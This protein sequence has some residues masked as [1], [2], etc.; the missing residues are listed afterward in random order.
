MRTRRTDRARPMTAN[1]APRTLGDWLISHRFFPWRWSPLLLALISGLLVWAALPPLSWWPLGWIAPL[2]WLLLIRQRELPGRHPYR[3]IYLASVLCWA[4]TMQGIRLA[5][6]ANYIGLVALALYLGIYLPLF[7]A[8]A[9]FAHHRWK[10]TL[11][12]AAPVVWVGVEV[13]RGY[14]PLGFSMALLGHT[15]IEQLTLV[16]IAD[17]FGPYTIS[18]VLMLVASCAL[19]VTYGSGRGNRNVWP[20]VVPVVILLLVLVY[21]RFRLEQAAGSVQEPLRVALI[22]GSIDTV[23]NDDPTRPHET[24]VQYVE[25]TERACTQF[26]PL[27]LVIWPETMFPIREILIDKGVSP[28]ADELLDPRRIEDTQRVFDQM[29]R[30][31]AWRIN[32]RPG[33]SP[34]AAEGTSNTGWVF[35]VS[36]WQLGNHPAR[37][38]NAALLA[39]PQGEIVGRYYKMRPVIFGEYVPFG[40]VI[41]ALYELF[42]LPNGLSR[43]STP[44]AWRVGNLRLSPSICFESTM[45]HLLRWHVAQL[46]RQGSPPDV[47]INLTNDGWFWGS[48]ILDIQLNCAVLRAIELRRPFLIAANTGFS[49]WIDGNGSIRAQGPRRATGVLLAEVVPDAR[50]SLYARWGD[51]PALCGTLFCLA[52]VVAALA[53]RWRRGG[54]TS[55]VPAS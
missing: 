28:Q 22:Q 24:F 10:L 41:P 17:I 54:G 9:R 2:G 33:S 46:T 14:G 13:A 32:Q 30:T 6:W 31:Q 52:V 1:A 51:G 4:L 29:V 45:P 19:R 25:L 37:R 7:I 11:A 35:G 8:I 42:P 23:F 36:T 20:V 5:H 18:F 40:D 15:Q 26:A 44:V 16:Q 55:V 38:Y 49:A 47:L 39:D 50:R 12:V 53:S 27:D 34:Q 21:G 43:G 3:G 48:S